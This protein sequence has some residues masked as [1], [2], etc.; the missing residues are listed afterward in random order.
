VRNVQFAT[1]G[2][3]PTPGYLHQGLV[4]DPP[5]VVLGKSVV[6]LAAAYDSQRMVGEVP[7]AETL[8]MVLTVVDVFPV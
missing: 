2:A 4:G 1:M 3:I 8:S 7:A 6:G 5:F